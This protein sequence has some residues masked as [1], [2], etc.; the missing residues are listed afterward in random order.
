MR[1]GTAHFLL[2]LMPHR[3]TTLDDRR[4]AEEVRRGAERSAQV[5]LK[6]LHPDYSPR[7]L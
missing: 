2:F 6:C 5:A 3:M 7:F 4:K 1:V